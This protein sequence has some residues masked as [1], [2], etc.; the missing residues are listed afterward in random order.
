MDGGDDWIALWMHSI[1]LNCT[2][3]MVKMINFMLCVFYHSWDFLNEDKIFSGEIMQT[4][5]VQSMILL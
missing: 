4:I 2:L 3:K 5:T 1:P